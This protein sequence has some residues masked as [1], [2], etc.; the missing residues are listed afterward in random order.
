M[1]KYSISTNPLI[2]QY[3]SEIKYVNN[4]SEASQTWHRPKEKQKYWVSDVWIFSAEEN[5]IKCGLVFFPAAISAYLQ[6]TEG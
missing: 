5:H 3:N 2:P 4:F 1:N 6:C